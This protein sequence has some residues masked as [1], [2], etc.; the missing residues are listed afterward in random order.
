MFRKL[1]LKGVARADASREAESLQT[2]RSEQKQL[3]SIDQDFCWSQSCDHSPH[4]SVKLITSIRDLLGSGESPAS[5][6]FTPRIKV[7]HLPVYPT[8]AGGPRSLRRDSLFPFNTRKH[9]PETIMGGCLKTNVL[10]TA[11]NCMKPKEGTP[12]RWRYS[13]K[14]TSP[15]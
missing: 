11:V 7:I 14:T 2:Y 5:I 3:K 9:Q 4:L 6:V 1:P 8:G 12:S 13:I 10:F 15:W